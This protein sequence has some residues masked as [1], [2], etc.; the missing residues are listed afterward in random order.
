MKRDCSK[1]Q[2][3]LFDLLIIGG[4]VHGA[5][6]ARRLAAAGYEVALVEKDDFCQA[7]SANS[8]KILHGGLRYL[9]HADF[10]RMRE[11]IKARREFMQLAPHLVRP[12]PCLMPT[13]GFGIHSKL[14]M[15]IALLVNDLISFDRNKGLTPDKHLGRGGILPRN[16][17][18]QIIAGLTD[19][20]IT[21]AARW[22][23]TLLLNSERMVLLLLHQ[24]ADAGAVLGNYL[25]AESVK[26]IEGHQEV[27]VHDLLKQEHF[28]VKSKMVI[29]CAG[30]WVDGLISGTTE[31]IKPLALARAVNIVVDRSFFGEYGVGL[32][33]SSEYKDKDMVVQ[34]GKRL[35][36]FVPWRGKTMIGTTYRIDQLTESPIL[37]SQSDVG[38]MVA[39]VNS[40]YPAA[41]ISTKDVVFS[42][43]GMVPAYPAETEEQKDNPRLLK[44]S[45][46]VDQQNGMLSVRGVKYTTALQ[47]ARDL[48]TVLHKKDFL[49]AKTKTGK[50]KEK[51]GNAALLDSS[52]LKEFPHLY[53]QYGEQCQ[54]I[55]QIMQDEPE[56]Q[57]LLSKLPPLTA[58]EVLYGIREE[59]VYHLADIVLRRTE[60]G[61]CGC[62]EDSVLQQVAEVMAKELQ[63][64]PDQCQ[65]EL[66]AMA[67][68]YQ[69][70]NVRLP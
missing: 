39:E 70:M 45:E 28:V 58:A 33:G 55:L 14:A 29:N 48:E 16:K 64:S 57:K 5:A 25:R 44:H 40:I 49:A 53:Q 23:D 7:T 43:V 65:Q 18:K 8:L 67:E 4:G 62:P 32:E 69:S 46:I 37:S 6:A 21:G 61:S 41:K 17:A 12:L 60:L 2:D 11:S 47:L 31:D 34:R 24:A 68:I 54:E 66:T 36:F 27:T 56:S 13:K 20:T 59:M 35:F 1:L 50:V 51:K 9:Q 22:Y 42:H 63:W 52:L 15:G 10:R 30:P 3:T 38:E 19:K 26:T